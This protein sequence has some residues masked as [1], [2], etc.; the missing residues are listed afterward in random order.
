MDIRHSVTRESTQFLQ[1][2]YLRKIRQQREELKLCIEL[3]KVDL[4]RAK[5]ELEKSKVAY[6]TYFSL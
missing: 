2:L 6:I 1:I 5:L 4:E 3:Q